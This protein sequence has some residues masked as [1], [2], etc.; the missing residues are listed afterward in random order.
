MT[1]VI[2]LATTKGGTGKTTLAVSLASYWNGRGVKVAALDA[3]P[4]QNL[5][6]WL[7]KGKLQDIPFKAEADENYLI[8]SIDELAQESDVVVVDMAG[9]GN[10]ALVYAIG[11][12][13]LVIIPARTSEDDVLEALKTRQIIKNAQK[14]TRKDIGYQVVLTQVKPGTLVVEHTKKQFGAFNVPLFN[15]E[16]VN[17][18]VFQ[19]CRFEGISP[20]QSNDEKAIAELTEFAQEV[21]VVIGL[22]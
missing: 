9:V 14:L 16:I 17:R 1:K 15:S 20:F 18:T 8:D 5:K 6:N 11:I 3:D 22:N 2:T 7:V 21:E 19:Q 10:Q 13:S 4:N 12:S